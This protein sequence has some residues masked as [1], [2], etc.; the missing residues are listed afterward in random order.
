M[1][2]LGR[3]IYGSGNSL[4][5]DMVYLVDQMPG[6]IAECKAFCDTMKHANENLNIAVIEGG[7]I[8]KCFKGTVDELNN[9]IYCT[10]RLH[11]QDTKLI[12]DH[13]VERDVYL[14]VIRSV[15]SILSHFSK[16]CLRVEIKKALKGT[17]EDRL[18]ALRDISLLDN[19]EVDF[20]SLNPNMSG[21]D[22]MKLVAFQIGQCRGL[23]DGVELYTKNEI[24]ERYAVLKKYLGRESDD[25]KSLSLELHDFYLR[26][27]H[28][29]S[30][31]DSDLVESGRVVF[32]DG[33]YRNKVEYDLKLEKKV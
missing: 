8:S 33:E 14:K 22:V 18:Y 19:D 3:Y 15:R 27:M 2:I 17:W 25:W 4:D 26:L 1:E 12:I 30:I 20:D 10:Y 32:H 21:R 9:A 11:E 24:G 13:M 6:S 31:V 7:V 23:F 29:F 16:S 5:T 28:N